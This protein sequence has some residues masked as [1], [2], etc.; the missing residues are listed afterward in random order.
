MSVAARQ[1]LF[2]LERQAHVAA[3]SASVAAMEIP[4]HPV[5]TGSH[6]MSVWPLSRTQT[7]GPPLAGGTDPKHTQIFRGSKRPGDRSTQ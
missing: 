2:A 6:F 1:G 5:G 4:V 7:Y 3:V